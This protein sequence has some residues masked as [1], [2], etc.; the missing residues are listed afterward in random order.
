MRS[1]LGPQAKKLDSAEKWT[2]LS[3]F[4]CQHGREALSYATLQQ[5]MEY[6]IHDLGYIAFTTATHP[7]LA[8][9]PRRIVLADPVCAVDDLPLLLAAFLKEYPSPVFPVVSE[10]CAR[11]LRQMGFKANCIGYE[12]ELPVQSYNTLGNWK[13]LDMIKRARNEAKREGVTIR[14][15]DIE[16]I[17]LDQLDAISAKW[18]GGKTVND[19]EIWVYARRPVYQH[20]DGVR[21]FVAFNRD[22][23]AIGYVF[24]DPMYR[25][26]K[27]FGYA[28]NTVRCDEAGYGRLATAIHMTAIE[29]FRPEGIEVL[30][31]MLCPFSGIDAGI[32]SDHPVM[33]WYFQFSERYGGEIYN[34]KGISFHKSKYR[35]KPNPLYFV[36]NSLMPWNDVYLSFLTSDISKGYMAT[37]WLLFVGIYKE[38][39]R[40][41]TKARDAK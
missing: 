15:V 37:M 14:E 8:R 11:I 1:I 24:Y 13:E 34:F 32:Y 38:M 35:G 21:R 25:D 5:G 18:I 2:L 36:S 30:N 40:P 12:P 16:S 4:I 9:K 10:R 41:K 29:A 6:F 23:V 20:E 17:P 7:V 28:A 39:T 3:P 19:R 33:R 31:L 22:G 26:G 27:I